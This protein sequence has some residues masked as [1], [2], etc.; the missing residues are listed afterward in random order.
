MWTREE[1]ILNQVAYKCCLTFNS[2]SLPPGMYSWFVTT[3]PTFSKQPFA[4]EWSCPAFHWRYSDVKNDVFWDVTPCG[5]CKNR[6]FGGTWHLLHQGDKNRWTRNSTRIQ[7][8]DGKIRNTFLHV[9]NMFWHLSFSV[10]VQDLACRYD[11]VCFAYKINSD[12]LINMLNVASWLC[13]M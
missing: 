13:C 4:R 8:K 12:L 10:I 6:R 5:S 11:S 2:L 9:I 3:V 7:E 1:A